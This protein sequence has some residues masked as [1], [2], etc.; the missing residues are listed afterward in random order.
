M[1]TPPRKPFNL[2][3][4]PDS[5]QLRNKDNAKLSLPNGPFYEV[6]FWHRAVAPMDKGKPAPHALR[7]KVSGA[8]A[9]ADRLSRKTRLEPV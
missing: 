2:S 4:D 9:Y 7:P 1:S 5:D 6:R 3:A 8:S